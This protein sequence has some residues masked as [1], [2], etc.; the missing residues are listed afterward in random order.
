M[1]VIADLERCQGYV[2]CVM[3]AGDFFDIDDD[4][5]VVVLVSE[6]ETGQLPLIESAIRQCPVAAL[7]LVD[8]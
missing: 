7:A 8:A 3:E 6:P 5:K 4:G 2:C 1:R